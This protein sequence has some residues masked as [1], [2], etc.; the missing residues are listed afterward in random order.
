VLETRRVRRNVCAEGSDVALLEVVD[1]AVRVSSPEGREA[2]G[3]REVELEVMEADGDRILGLVLERVAAA[4]IES[5]DA[6]PKYQ[7]ALRMLGADAGG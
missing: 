7:R 2:G 4:G 1:D 3:F 5:E 6:M